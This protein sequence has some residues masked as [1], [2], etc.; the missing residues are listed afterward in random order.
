VEYRKS[1]LLGIRDF[2]LFVEQELKKRR[3]EAQ[4]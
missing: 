4:S 2:I 1:K 3:S